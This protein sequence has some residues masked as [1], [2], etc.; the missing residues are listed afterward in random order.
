MPVAEVKEYQD[1]CREYDGK[2]RAL[3]ALDEKRRASKGGNGEATW[4]DADQESYDATAATALEAKAHADSLKTISEIAQDVHDMSQPM[5][6]VPHNGAK[7][8]LSLREAMFGPNPEV[9]DGTAVD[10]SSVRTAMTK[11]VRYDTGLR[12]SRKDASY[13]IAIGTGNAVDALVVPTYGDVTDYPVPP[14]VADQLFGAGRTN[15]NVWK[16]FLQDAPTFNAGSVANT[17]VSEDTKAKSEITYELITETA[18]VIA[19]YI[20]IHKTALANIP[21]LESIIREQLLI[22]AAIELDRQLI[23]G[24]GTS[25]EI[26]GI[27]QRGAST[28]GIPGIQTHTSTGLTDTDF[29]DDVKAMATKSF[30]QSWVPATVAGMTPALADV[31]LTAKSSGDGNYV[32]GIIPFM[33]AAGMQLSVWGLKIVQS[34]VFLN[35]DTAAGTVIVGNPA[36]GRVVTQEDANVTVGWVDKQFI[37]NAETLLAETTVGLEVN[38]PY[39]YCE[40]DCSGVS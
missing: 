39:G 22:G 13:G 10:G 29:L 5:A 24:S 34:P 9:K 40:M 25:D 8:L 20:P 7:R 27:T 11:G 17:L 32:Y 16:Y 30:T 38:R 3:L 2:A 37:Q 14:T 18:H 28:G 6:G 15:V 4:T 23:W 33:T 1:A 35:P 12:I 36:H 31:L 26:T 19:H 21:Q